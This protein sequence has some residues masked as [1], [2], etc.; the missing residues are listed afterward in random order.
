MDEI[1]TSLIASGTGR[2]VSVMFDESISVKGKS[3]GIK[4]ASFVNVKTKVIGYKLRVLDS[5]GVMHTLS[6]PR[7]RWISTDQLMGAMFKA[8]IVL[9]ETLMKSKY[10]TNPENI[11]SNIH[12]PSFS[13]AIATPGVYYTA[14]Y[15]GNSGLE[16]VPGSWSTKD[17]VFSLLRPEFSRSDSDKLAYVDHEIRYPNGE[18]GSEETSRHLLDEP[19]YLFCDAIKPTYMGKT[20]QQVLDVIKMTYFGQNSYY[21]TNSNIQF[22]KFSVDELIEINFS[23]QSLEGSFVEFDYPVVLHLGIRD[24]IQLR[25]EPLKSAHFTYFDMEFP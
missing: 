20:K 18:D 10:K 9:Y 13:P 14:I 1:E 16:I 4:S 15:Y 6:L 12:R 3:I 11:P 2:S 21:F 22:H 8:F 25:K 23:F 17:D 5:T 24:D 19:V 7:F